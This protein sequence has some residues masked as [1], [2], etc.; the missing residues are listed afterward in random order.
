[1]QVAAGNQQ[2]HLL[3][4]RVR[5]GESSSTELELAR[6][7]ADKS[8]MQLQEARDQTGQTRL[9]VAAALGVPER[10]LVGI[11]LNLAGLD[12]FPSPT[13]VTPSREQALL[14]RTDI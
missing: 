6:I 7:A 9:A 10:A 14:D 12:A 8:A 5:V 3:A 13:R 4:E 1:R 11:R 2:T